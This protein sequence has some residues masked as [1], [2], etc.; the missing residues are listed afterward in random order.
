MPD[1]PIDRPVPPRPDLP[2]ASAGDEGWA[3]VPTWRAVETIPLLVTVIGVT[4]L[5]ALPFTP[6]VDSCSGVFVLVSLA[7]EAA[8]I[9][10]TLFWIRYVSKSRLTALGVP[11][12]PLTDAGIGVAAGAGMFVAAAGVALI[13]QALVSVVLGHPPPEPQQVDPCVRGSALIL[14]APVVILGAPLGEELLF[15]GFLY[16]GLRRRFSVWP[17]AL[18]SGLVFGVIHI[19]PESG[20]QA[21]AT[22]I[23]VPALSLLGVALAHLYERRKS[24][25]APIAGHAAFNLIGYLAI[26]L[27]RT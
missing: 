9:A 25:V 13:T 21:A 1:D 2:E 15:R 4:F 11:R 26:A 8:F 24:L 14:L 17:A 12:R 16:R 22:A 7:G 10:T 23:L 6:L 19:S 3:A 20:R 27:S 18:I 5:F